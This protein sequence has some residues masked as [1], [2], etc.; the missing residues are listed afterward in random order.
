MQYLLSNNKPLLGASDAS[1][2]NGNSSHAWILT[3]GKL[4]HINDPLMHLSGGGQV[5]GF[6]ADMSP[7]CGEI[8]GQTTLAIM[9]NNLLKA[10]NQENMSVIFH[11]DNIGV[12]RK[13]NGANL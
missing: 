9:S 12:Q 1:L 6:H 8:H 13:C 2:K 10:H 5:D 7:A 4:D 3:I 11:G